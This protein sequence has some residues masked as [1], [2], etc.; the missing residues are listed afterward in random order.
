MAGR[1]DVELLITGMGSDNAERRMRAILATVRP[2]QVLTCGYAGGLHP[3][4]RSG[5]VVFCADDEFPLLAKLLEAGARPGQFHC[6]PR[7]VS[8]AAG[9]QALRTQTGADAVEMESAIIRRICGEHR[10][11]SATVRV[12]SDPAT[13]DLPLDFNALVKPDLSLAYGKL[14]AALLR[15]PV[16]LGA[17]VRLQCQTRIAAQNLARV[18][19]SVTATGPTS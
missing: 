15:S 9:K 16:R 13:E 17:L 14:A 1:T 2:D 8:S 10:L 3:E 18:L 7:I 11:P 12:I 19:A 5:Q 4:L 6:S